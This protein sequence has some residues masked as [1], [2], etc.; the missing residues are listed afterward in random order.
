MK[1]TQSKAE[2]LDQ[3]VLDS[4]E[5]NEQGTA[6][7]RNM[8]KEHNKRI[9]LLITAR[10]C[11]DES[12]TE[13]GKT[14]PPRRLDETAFDVQPNVIYTAIKAGLANTIQIENQRME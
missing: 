9:D 7:T 6:Q 11:Q 8:K 2:P 1:N 5:Q 14:L 3:I 10:A 4:R 12:Q 13:L